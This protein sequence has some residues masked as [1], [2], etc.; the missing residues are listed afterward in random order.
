[1]AATGFVLSLQPLLDAVT[2]A[3]ATGV[4]SVAEVASQVAKQVPGV[5]RLVRSASGQLVAY[6]FDGTSRTPQVVNPN[7]G[8]VFGAYAPSP[9]FAFIAELHRSLF[10]GGAGH[11]ASGIASLVIFGLSLSGVLLLVRRW[12]G[13]R[14]LLGRV[15]GTG[16]QR[17]H[18]P[19]AGGG[20]HAPA[21]RHDRRI[22]SAVYFELVPS[23]SLASRSRRPARTTPAAVA[24][25]HG[26]GEHSPD[27]LARACLPV[28]D[29]PSDVFTVT[30]RAGLG[31]VDQATRHDALIHA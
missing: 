19:G 3:P 5:E 7:T 10:L 16:S 25:L 8:E 6:G 14:Q 31:Y 15:R 11:I 29:D 13:W 2:T 4:P 18:H 21:D 17:F 24:S 27:R 22:L 26:V 28:A 23:A 9:V 30:A 1:M 12:C 20:V